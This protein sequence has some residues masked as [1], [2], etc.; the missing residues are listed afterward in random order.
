MARNRSKRSDTDP[1]RMLKDHH[2]RVKKL[3]REFEQ[4]DRD[5][6]EACREIVEQACTELKIHT[7]L[8][9]EIFYPASR[10]GV[11]E[12]LMNEAEI[13]HESAKMLIR[14]LDDL[15]PGDPRYGAAFIVLGEYV[16]HHIKE[17]ENEMFPQVREAKLDLE[18]IAEQPRTRK[19]ELMG[20]M[21]VPG[22]EDAED[23]EETGR[24]ERRAGTRTTVRQ[25]PR[26][27][28]GAN[29]PFVDRAS[30]TANHERLCSG[31]SSAGLSSPEAGRA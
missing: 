20:E 8:E 5:D 15:Q 19:D 13:E 11:E 17:E 24:E 2:N 9:E 30:R 26:A 7:T 14:Q 22:Q 31:R 4:V 18:T 12:D 3:F 1:L 29:E 6:P 27:L 28:I 25:G 23:S 10:E 21:E 16:K